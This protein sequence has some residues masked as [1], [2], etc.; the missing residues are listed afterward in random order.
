MLKKEEMKPGIKVVVVS[1]S[2]GL[3]GYYAGGGGPQRL[4]HI[5]VGGHRAPAGTELE[6]VKG[7]RK[8]HGR[9]NSVLARFADGRQGEVYWCELRA[10]CEVKE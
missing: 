3:S 7:P 5:N 4:P 2:D 1:P 8:I 10:S 9:I 6:V